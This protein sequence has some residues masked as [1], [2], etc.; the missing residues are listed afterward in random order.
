MNNRDVARN[1]EKYNQLRCKKTVAGADYKLDQ[2]Y[3][4]TL[5]SLYNMDVVRVYYDSVKT[6][7]YIAFTAVEGSDYYL[8]DYFC[9]KNEER[10]AKIA[11]IIT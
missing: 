11:L 10:S 4:Y 9:T 3:D 6:N 5:L 7:S 8:W 2:Y 1:L